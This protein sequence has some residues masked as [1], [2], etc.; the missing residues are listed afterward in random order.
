MNV[1]VVEYG[2]IDNSS[3]TLIPYYA[4]NLNIPDMFNINSAPVLGLGNTSFPVWVGAVVGGGSVVNGMTFDRASTADYDAWE[5]LGNDGWGWDGLLPY[6][7][8]VGAVQC[9]C[10]AW[11]A[12]CG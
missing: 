3:T 5:A 8:K 4:N 6:F 7:K 9:I 11:R 2:R 12:L 1:L 10:R